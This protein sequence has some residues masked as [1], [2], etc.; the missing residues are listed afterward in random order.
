MPDVARRGDAAVL[1]VQQAHVFGVAGGEIIAELG[2]AVGGAVVHEDDLQF[3]EHRLLFKRLQ[4][5]L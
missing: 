1:L 5:A 2:A 3:V 4:A